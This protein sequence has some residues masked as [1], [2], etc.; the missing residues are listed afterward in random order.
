MLQGL[1]R[2]G[3]ISA[4]RW[5]VSLQAAHWMVGGFFGFIAIAIGIL[6]AILVFSENKPQH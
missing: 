6:F 2:T 4:L 3:G 5:T 1:M